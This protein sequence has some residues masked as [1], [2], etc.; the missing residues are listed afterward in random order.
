MSNSHPP[1]EGD[2][3]T[4]LLPSN[5]WKTLLP[6]ISEPTIDAG[7]SQLIDFKHSLRRADSANDNVPVPVLA[8]E[9]LVVLY[10][11]TLP[12]DHDDIKARLS[13]MSLLLF[14]ELLSAIRANDDFE[15]QFGAFP[16]YKFKVDPSATKHLC[17]GHL[18][19]LFHGC[20]TNE[21]NT[22]FQY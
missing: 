7:T 20:S 10:H 11:L 15:R 4:S 6:C 18:F 17:S 21:C 5:D 16:V 9:L 12:A 13:Q 1:F 22:C 14:G 3:T 2:E 19:L 8:F